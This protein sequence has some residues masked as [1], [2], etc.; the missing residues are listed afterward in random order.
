M[1]SIFL[2]SLIKEVFS[3][4]KEK[5]HSLEFCKGLGKLYFFLLPFFA[6]FS[7][8]GPPG[9][10]ISKNLAAL[11]KASPA[12]SSIVVPIWEY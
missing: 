6:K 10:P 8:A 4:E 11:S 5:L 1:G 7:N 12:A 2:A 3:P 9:Y